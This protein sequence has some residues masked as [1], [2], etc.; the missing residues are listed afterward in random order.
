MGRV[1][2]I[3]FRVTALIL[4]WAVAV[5]SP[6]RISFAAEKNQSRGINCDIQ[7]QA[8]VQ[9]LSDHEVRLNITPKPVKAMTD[10]A[11]YVK[12]SGRVLDHPP[13]IDLGMPGMNMGP[14]RIRLEPVGQNSYAGKGVIVKCPSGRTI[15]RATVT[16]PEKGAVDFIF[17]VIY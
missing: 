10:L 3:V 15:W 8:C 5:T 13:Y 1:S 14:N 17:K 4:F 2:R 6:G 12:I 16:I 9:S 11:F 7:K